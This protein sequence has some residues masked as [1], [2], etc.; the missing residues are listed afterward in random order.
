MSRQFLPL[1]VFA[2]MLRCGYATE[3]DDVI[4]S[5]QESE[6]LYR[7]LD[8]RWKESFVLLSR[9]S[10]EN[11]I[12]DEAF[13][14]RSVRQGD[15]LFLEVEGDKEVVGGNEG[16]PIRIYRRLGYDG[17]MTRSLDDLGSYVGNVKDKSV[18]DERMLD[19]HLLPFRHAGER[20][21]LSAWLR[22]KEAVLGHPLGLVS[23]FD[24]G[25][26]LQIE[27]AGDE[28]FA[29]AP[30][31]RVVLKGL[32]P[33]NGTLRV[34]GRREFW[35]DREKNYLPVRCVSYHD[36]Y[37]PSIPIEECSLSDLREI[38]PGVW[39]P[40]SCKL[41]VYDEVE[42]L[43][44][45]RQEV[46]SERE[47]VVEEVSIEPQHDVSF[48]RDVTFPDGAAVYTVVGGEIVSGRI[49]GRADRADRRFSGPRQSSFVGIIVGVNLAVLV[50]ALALW[51]VRRTKPS[52][53]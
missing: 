32:R 40:F 30:C 13:S 22:G 3:L 2:C 9:R 5:L 4:Q 15:K 28:A 27:F 21:P 10:E 39:F 48:F 47:I 29:G 35:L 19:P 18:Y 6:S 36:F 23:D 38:K 24:G 49:E 7:N 16:Q 26:E 11:L 46:L 43:D 8:V 14:G 44:H 41:I 1:L 33:K 51:W 31:C 52:K 20:V 17:E 37:S 12:L 34:T 42:L 25:R 45:K 53:N 50:A